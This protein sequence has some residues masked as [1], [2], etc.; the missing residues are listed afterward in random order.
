MKSAT[1]VSIATVALLIAV[2]SLLFTAVTPSLAHDSGQYNHRSDLYT[3]QFQGT[4][5]QAWHDGLINGALVW[6][7][8]DNQCHDFRRLT[9]GAAIVTNRGYWDGPGNEFAITWGAHNSIQ[10]DEAEDWHLNVNVFTGPDTLDLW[11]V[12]AHE[13]G[14]ALHL[15][16][17]W[18][19]PET[20]YGAYGYGL[21][22]ARSLENGDERNIRL[23]YPS[24]TCGGGGSCLRAPDRHSTVDETVSTHPGHNRSGKPEYVC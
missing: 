22:W 19:W 14:H 6:D 8:V 24:G 20:M 9:S 12:A 4:I 15:V 21:N 16:H 1:R 3:W 17:S 13:F 5:P 23:Q 11:S 18:I 10:F 2:M 7:H